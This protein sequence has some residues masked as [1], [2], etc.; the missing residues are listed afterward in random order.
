M[1]MLPEEDARGIGER[2]RRRRQLLRNASKAQTLRLVGRMVRL[3]G[4]GEMAHHQPDLDARRKRRHRLPAVSTSAGAMPSRD[5]P[6][7][8]CTATGSFLPGRRRCLA[9][10]GKL[11][12]RC[13]PP[14]I[15]PAAAHSSS[16][17]G[18][19]AVQHIDC[20][21]RAQ[22]CAQRKR[23]RRACATKKI[24]QPSRAGAGATSAAPRP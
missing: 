6:L 5:M 4:A 19:N 10:G 24:S 17:P 16:A 12:E 13:W 18:V 20:R 23:L 14:A 8:T 2:R 7:S 21:L 22:R 15:R 9:P 11:L 1:I 3:V